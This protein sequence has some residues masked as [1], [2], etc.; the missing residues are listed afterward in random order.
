VQSGQFFGVCW[1]NLALSVGKKEET[2]LNRKDLQLCTTAYVY[3]LYIPEPA[4]N[5]SQVE[6][7]IFANIIEAQTQNT[8]DLGHPGIPRTLILKENPDYDTLKPLDLVLS[9][10]GPKVQQY[11]TEVVYVHLSDIC[12]EVFGSTMGSFKINGKRLPRP[13]MPSNLYV[14]PTKK[15]DIQPLRVLDIDEATVD[16]NARVMEAIVQELGISLPELTGSQVLITGRF[17][18]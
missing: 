3:P 2:E 13:Q 12:H 1:D 14:M 15:T 4:A 6:K 10:G 9:S 5:A 18:S 16:G 8:T 17:N 11:W 7:K